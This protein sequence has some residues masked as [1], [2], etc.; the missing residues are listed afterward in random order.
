MHFSVVF[1]LLS[2]VLAVYEIQVRKKPVWSSALRS[3][4]FST[5]GLQ[6]LYAFVGHVWRA[7]ATAANI[8]W[9]AGNPFQREVAFANLGLAVLGLTSF[10]VNSPGFWVATSISA[11]VFYL[12]AATTHLQEQMIKRNYAPSNAGPIVYVTLIEVLLYAVL[13]ILAVRQ[14]NYQLQG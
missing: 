4:L 1:L 3:L 10:F 12:G 9:P 11:G 8:G 6:G 14:P 5:V 7:D 13:S 2:V